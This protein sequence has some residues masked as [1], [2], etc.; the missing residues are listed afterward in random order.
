MTIDLKQMIYN[1]MKN[2]KSIGIVISLMIYMLGMEKIVQAGSP[3]DKQTNWEPVT[4]NLTQLLNNGWRVY[5]HSSQRAATSPGAPGYRAYDET[6]YTF[7]L[8]KNDK[9]IICLIQDP[10]PS[11]AISGCRAL[12]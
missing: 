8:I 10:R 5:G 11:K 2:K 3:V 6:Q 12:N 1:Y 4:M 9:H 7:L